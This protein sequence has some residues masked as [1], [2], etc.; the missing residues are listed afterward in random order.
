ML[1]ITVFDLL[2]KDDMVIKSFPLPCETDERDKMIK[3][4]KKMTR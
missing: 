3:N 2:L 1:E 4:N